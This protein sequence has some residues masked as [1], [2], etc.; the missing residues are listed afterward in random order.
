MLENL[1][2]AVQILVSLLFS[3]CCRWST[4]TYAKEYTASCDLSFHYVNFAKPLVVLRNK[5]T[6][7]KSHF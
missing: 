7:K 6:E 3:I 1:K 5:N 2:I 4:R